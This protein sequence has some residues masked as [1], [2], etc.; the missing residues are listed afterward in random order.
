MDFKEKLERVKSRR[1]VPASYTQD[2]L[3][4]LTAHADSDLITLQKSLLAEGTPSQGGSACQYARLSMKE[5]NPTITRK[6]L[7]SGE[8]VKTQI[9][10]GLKSLSCPHDLRY[11]GSLPL[12]V[13]IRS[14][15]DVDLLVLGTRYF[16]FDGPFS[17]SSRY[18]GNPDIDMDNWIK[19][20]RSKC[21]RILEG[22]YPAARIDKSG[23]KAV[24]ISGG[25]LARK[26]DVVPACWFEGRDFQISNSEARK[27]VEVFDVNT[28]Q[29]MKN[30]PFYVRDEVNQK[31]VETN[32]GAKRLIRLLKSLKD[33]SG[34]PIQL[35]SFD[36]MSIAY[37]I[38]SS[39][40]TYNRYYPY[41]IIN[42]SLLF[43]SSPAAA[44]TIFQWKTIDSTR[45]IFDSPSKK[46]GFST[47]MSSLQL[48]CQEMAKELDLGVYGKT[49]NDLLQEHFEE[50]L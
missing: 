23:G 46:S 4:S 20:L 24:A 28:G 1:Q 10:S 39:L 33:D 43:L 6:S 9:L 45:E 30:F 42:Q 3:A 11:Q 12:N 15:H 50:I 21:I 25:S 48:L 34:A 29:W 19:S 44:S 16:Y 47:L 41:R 18:V 14:N 32:S 36:I 49:Y 35:S 17:P 8:R 13:H 40:I 5:V 37:R 27:G 7:D 31:D 38:P 26:I 22:A 2:T